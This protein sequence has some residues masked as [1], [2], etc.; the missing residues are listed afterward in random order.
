MSYNYVNQ[1]FVSCSMWYWHGVLPQDI[2]GIHLLLGVSAHGLTVFCGEQAYLTP[3]NNF[4]WWARPQRLAKFSLASFPDLPNFKFYCKRLKT[5]EWEGLEMGVDRCFIIV[6]VS[7]SHFTACVPK[8]S[9]YQKVRY[10]HNHICNIIH[11]N[12]KLR[13]A[14]C[15]HTAWLLYCR[16]PGIFTADN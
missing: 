6:W 8:G 2:S 11:P 3:L 1:T 14:P 4:P 7:L 5:G 16:Q 10:V 9:L 13:Q 12:S 15:E